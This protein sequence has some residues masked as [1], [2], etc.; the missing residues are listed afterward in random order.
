MEP[1]GL[2]IGVAGLATVF[3]TCLECFEY[4]QLGRNFGKDYGKCLLRLDATK[5]RLSRWGASVGL[6]PQTTQHKDILVQR[7]EYFLAQDL[8]EQIKDCFE[9]VE[10]LSTRYRQHALIQ[11]SDSTALAAYDAEADLGEEYRHLHNTMRGL[12]RNR[13]RY[14]SVLRK[15]KWALYEKRKF[16]SMIDDLSVFV[17]ELVELFPSQEERYRELCKDE[18]LTIKNEDELVLLNAVSGNDEMLRNAVRGRDPHGHSAVDWN[19]G[20][21]AKIWIG[22]KNSH[23]LESK[24]HTARRFIIS[25]SAHV[26]IGNENQGP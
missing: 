26:W 9:N 15:T 3:S 19:V 14:A 4:V 25:D 12:A 11:D 10:R 20:G 1:V 23:G 21:T 8:L 13:Q 5:L 16:D 7:R 2:V 18:V 24:T 6:G 17:K 22:D